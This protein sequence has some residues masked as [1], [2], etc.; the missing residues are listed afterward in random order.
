MEWNENERNDI[1]KNLKWN[2]CFMVCRFKLQTNCKLCHCITDFR[3]IC[4]QH[5]TVLNSHCGR[6][7]CWRNTSTM[8]IVHSCIGHNSFHIA[9]FFFLTSIKQT[10]SFLKL[11]KMFQLLAAVVTLQR[12]LFERILYNKYTHTVCCCVRISVVQT[13]EFE[14]VY[15]HKENKL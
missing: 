14:V 1:E 2:F 4:E 3:W 7:W 12:Q 6:W 5:W 13:M 8:F 15:S 9:R 10:C 11:R